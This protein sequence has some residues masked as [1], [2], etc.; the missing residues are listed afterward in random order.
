MRAT[1]LLAMALAAAGTLVPSGSAAAGDTV[2]E[3]RVLCRLATALD[4]FKHLEASALWRGQDPV[5]Q[6]EET[7][8]KLRKLAGGGKAIAHRARAFIGGRAQQ[9]GGGGGAFTGEACAK[10]IKGPGQPGTAQA[11]T[12]LCQAKEAKAEAEELINKAKILAHEALWGKESGTVKQDTLQ[13]KTWADNPSASTLAGVTKADAHCVASNVLWLCMDGTNTHTANPCFKNAGVTA[14][15][16]LSSHTHTRCHGTPATALQVWT[17]LAPLCINATAKETRPAEELATTA[18]A[19]A[20]NVISQIHD[21][22]NNG[23]KFILGPQG[24][25]ASSR[26]KGASEICIKFGSASNKVKEIYWHARV[27]SIAAAVKQANTLAAEA[28]TLATHARLTAA[29]CLATEEEASTGNNNETQENSQT[30]E[31][32]E[33]EGSDSEAQH[34]GRARRH[35]ESNKDEARTS[36]KTKAQPATSQ[37]SA[38]TA[39]RQQHA[40]AALAILA[41]RLARSARHE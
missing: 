21:V 16:S 22:S 38:A 2:R 8:R 9:E 23:Q 37:H 3:F 27:R 13:T 31:D 19:A 20:E 34:G 41:T 7:L 14:L 18:L 25:T 15:G 30:K 36:E 29:Q 28:R 10:G 11:D 40:E 6:I 35:T 1:F 12:L 17:A 5:T 32:Q 39:H 4:A 33:A 26:N 24:S